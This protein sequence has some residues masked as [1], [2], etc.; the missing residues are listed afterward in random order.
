LSFRILIDSGKRSPGGYC[1]V[2]SIDPDKVKAG[3]KNIDGPMKKL[4]QEVI[5][6]SPKLDKVLKL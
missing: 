2:L 3:T 1:P 5:P 6:Y 4:T